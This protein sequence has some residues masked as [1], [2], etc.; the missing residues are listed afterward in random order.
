MC[1]TSNKVLFYLYSQNIHTPEVVKASV[2]L[3]S[4]S[5]LSGPS[6][7]QPQLKHYFI[8]P[9]RQYNPFWSP[10]SLNRC[11]HPCL[12]PAGQNIMY[13]LFYN[14]MELIYSLLNI[15]KINHY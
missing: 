12:P 3:N 15:K 5:T 14:Y 13:F 11:L 4:K 10:V 7:G 6:C 8:L 1:I 9:C 2:T